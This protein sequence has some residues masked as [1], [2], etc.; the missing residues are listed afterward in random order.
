MPVL[1]AA[2]CALPVLCT[3]GGPTDDFV[4]DS[5]ARRIEAT[6]RPL[7]VKGRALVA[8]EPSLE[9]LITLMISVLEEEGW[10]KQA[11]LAGPAHVAANFT[12]D[13]VVD[14]LVRELWA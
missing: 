12:W 14:D 9:H 5:F 6:T 1:E 4:L 10:R 11:A 2:A 7:P 8:L 3:R 13:R